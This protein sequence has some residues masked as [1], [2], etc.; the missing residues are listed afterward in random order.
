MTKLDLFSDLTAGELSNLDRCDRAALVAKAEA[1][2]IEA[3]KSMGRVPV[4]CGSDIREAPAR[5][6][7][8]V[9]DHMAS[10]PKGEDGFELKPAGHDGRKTMA[11]ADA[12]DVMQAQRDRRSG[13]KA[14]RMFTHSQIAMGRQYATLVERHESAGVK[15]SSVESSGGGGDGAGFMDAV[16]ADAQ[17]IDR[18]RA[19]IGDGSAVVVRRH[20]PSKR[21]ARATITDRRLV[22]MVCVEGRTLTDVL[23]SHGWTVRADLV[24]DL[25]KALADALDRMQGPFRNPAREVVFF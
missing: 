9:F 4:E 13:G 7:V 21:G 23:R 20:R 6:P 24:R 10:Y 8:R 19:R 25:T 17:A 14:G 11:R 22:D 2:R 15:C 18:M 12:F 3:V 16:L 1:M 5:G